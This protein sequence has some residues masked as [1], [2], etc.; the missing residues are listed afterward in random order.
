[1]NELGEYRDK[2]CCF[3]G[4]FD[5]P[6]IGHLIQIMR[7]GQMFKSVIVPVLAYPEQK[8]SVQYRVQILKDALSMARG[9]YSVFANRE[10]FA[11]ITKE[12]ISMYNFDVYVSQNIEC[13]K[14]V[15]SLGY[16]V[17]YVDRA[18]DYSASEETTLDK[19]RTIL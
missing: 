18:Y 13:L 3:S 15:E 10:H 7:L 12:E 11:R 1:M 4:R 2:K 5:R 6:H 9:G 17:M 8:F 14:H 16:K 19:I